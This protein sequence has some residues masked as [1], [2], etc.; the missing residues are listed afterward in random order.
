MR[1]IACAVTEY[2]NFRAELEARKQ[3]AKIEQE[4]AELTQ[5]NEDLKHE[6]AELKLLERFLF[7]ISNQ[8]K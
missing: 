1:G 8:H 6:S 5:E 4:Y 3:E 7:S 2:K